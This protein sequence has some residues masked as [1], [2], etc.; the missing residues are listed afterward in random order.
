MDIVQVIP[1]GY[2]K[3]VIAAIL[4]VKKTIAEYPDTKVYILGM[5]VH[6]RYVVDA[7]NK[8]GAITLESKTLTKL[9][10]LNTINEGVVVFTAHGIDPKIMQ[11][12]KDKGLIVVDATCIDVTKNANLCLEY[13][14]DGYDVIY[15]GKKNHPESDAVI[16]L[17]SKIHLVT[18]KADLE[19]LKIKN[20]KILITN[21][22][23]MSYLDTAKL[24]EEI[25]LVYPTSTIMQEICDA[26]RTRQQAVKNLKNIDTLVVVGDPSSNNT[27]QLANIARSSGIGRVIKVETARELVDYK[28]SSDEKIAVTAGASTP[29]YLKSQVIDYLKT[30]KEEYLDINLDKIL[31]L[32]KG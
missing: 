13:I 9:E 32:R 27:T 30:G 8:L 10:L 16:A 5:L 1:S 2:C 7:F 15:I 18:N 24:I 25:K 26:T 4:K 28:F 12:A 3:G 14:N 23:T 11:Y 31:E 29:G 21:Q 19:N 22:T 20:E 6:N 17:D